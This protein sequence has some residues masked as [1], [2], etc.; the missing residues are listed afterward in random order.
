MKLRKSQ[1]M[2]NK[3]EELRK[4]EAQHWTE[5]NYRNGKKKKRVTV[6]RISKMGNFPE[7]EIKEVNR[8]GDNKARR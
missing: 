7:N 8:R 1:R 6:K 3:E 5:R 2:N 4:S